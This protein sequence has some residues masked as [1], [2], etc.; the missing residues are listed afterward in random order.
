MTTIDATRT[1]DRWPSHLDGVELVWHRLNRVHDFARF[2]RSEVGWAECDA[3]LDPRGCVVASHT[4]GRPGDQPLSDLLE[5][6]GSVGRAAKIDLKE[7]GP[8]LDGV[9]KA[10]GS[11]HLAGLDLWFNA[12]IEVIGGEAGFRG[13]SD[14]FPGARLSAPVDTIAGW[15]LVAPDEVVTLLDSTR[16]W[17]L[18]RLCV[19][20]QTPAFGSIVKI[21]ED[22]GWMTDVWDVSDHAHLQDALR[23]RPRSI[24]ADLGVLTAA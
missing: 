24:T 1:A 23:A 12:A 13:L 10:A 21:L 20:A 16:A 11:S 4:A 8:V 15:L 14:A 17:G 2:V 5:E 7:G 18:D 3:R 22:R 6:I 19:S 9:L